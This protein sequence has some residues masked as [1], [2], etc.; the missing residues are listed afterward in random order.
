MS[1]R[2]YSSR[3]DTWTSPRRSL[4]ESERIAAH[5]PLQPASERRSFIADACIALLLATALVALFVVPG[6]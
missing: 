5:G 3:P 6:A 2:N 1:K 4:S